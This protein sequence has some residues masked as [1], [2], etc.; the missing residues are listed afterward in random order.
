[1]TAASGERVLLCVAGLS[2]Q[3]ITETLYA[4]AHEGEG[5]LPD[6]VEVVTTTEGYRRVALTLLADDGGRGNVDRLCSDYGIDRERIAF[7]L[8]HIHVIQDALGQPLEDIVTE[9]DNAAAADLIHERIRSLTAETRQLH[10][11]LAGGRKTMGFYAGYSLSLYGRAGDRLSH[12]LVNPPF[13]SHPEF[14]YPPPR[15]VTLALPGRNDVVST[16]DAKVRLAD[17]PFVR[18][19]DE[20]GESLPYEDLRYSEAVERAQAVLRPPEL[21]LDLTERTA[22][23]QGQILH[24]STTQFLW[25]AWLADRARCGTAPVEFDESAL[26][27]LELWI[28]RLEGTGP[29]SLRDSIHSA[30]ADMAA[31]E[32]TNYFDRNRSRLNDAIE[33]RSGLPRRAADRYRVQ[34]DGRR[35]Q[36]GYFLALA[37]EQV[38]FTGEP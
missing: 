27:E 18:M 37:P 32:R 12:V 21:I 19:R 35:G 9:D 17:I 34:S 11:S 23:A 30:R 25:L 14:F 3:V 28:D 38:H 2:P 7:A 22:H 4:L 33:R 5:S 15:P 20:L 8:D 24:L 10:V 6:R 13:E 26:D 29:S 1:M 31:G 16:R 36:T